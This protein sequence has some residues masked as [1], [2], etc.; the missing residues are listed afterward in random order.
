MSSKVRYA[1]ENCTAIDTDNGGGDFQTNE[2]EVT[3]GIGGEWDSEEE[4]E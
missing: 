1:I 3:S 2:G 4:E